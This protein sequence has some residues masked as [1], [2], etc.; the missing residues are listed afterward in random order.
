MPIRASNSVAIFLKN[1][2]PCLG[3]CKIGMVVLTG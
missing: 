3:Y 2:M 1:C